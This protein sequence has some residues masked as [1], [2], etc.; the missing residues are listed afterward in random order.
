[1]KTTAFG[2]VF[3]PNF[4]SETLPDYARRAEAAGFAE[5]WL[6]DDCFLP[7]ALTA[8]AI[9][10]SATR[11]LKVCIG[12]LPAT[13]YN[14]LFAAMEIT[15]L[16]RNFP[17]RIVPGFGHGVGSWMQQIGAAPKSSLQT[18]EATVT[19]VRRLLAG[20][21][22]TVHSGAVNL[23][24]VQMHQ[25]PVEIPPLYVG[26]M[27][28]KSLR[29]AGRVGD[30][31]I[32]AGMCTPAYVRWALQH[33]QAGAAEGARA[34]PRV[35][36]NLDVKVNPDGQAA[37]AAARRSLAGRLPWAD[38]YLNALGIADEV[39]AFVQAHGVEGVAQEMPDAWLDAFAA[40]GT[41]EQAAAA[42]QRMVETGAD[43]VVF[44]P[45]D[46]DPDCLEEYARYLL[47][48]LKEP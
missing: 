43:S 21:A 39:A 31:A 24:A 38:V 6:W 28:E 19:A 1:M 35:V 37:R 47:P 5:L 10:L 7:G 17:G 41:P 2:V 40:A 32:L 25:T 46:G 42:V 3:H 8:A 36:A 34:R 29:L 22:V 48:L 20:E 16:A 30:G 14:P 26:G 9:A 4:P 11:R 15:T 18:L 33:I 23:E 27:R 45:L 12:L 44:Q 13:A